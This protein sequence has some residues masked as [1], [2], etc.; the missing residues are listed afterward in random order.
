[1]KHEALKRQHFV[2]SFDN[3]QQE[4]IFN[5]SRKQ[6]ARPRQTSSVMILQNVGQ[7]HPEAVSNLCLP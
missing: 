2:L 7:L 5:W 6:A 4:G 3:A 1:M